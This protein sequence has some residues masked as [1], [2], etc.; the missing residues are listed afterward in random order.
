MLTLEGRVQKVFK[1]PGGSTRDG[2]VVA[3]SARVQIV[4]EVPV[5]GGDSKLA[6][7][8]L[9]VTDRVAAFQ[10]AMGKLVRCQVD[11]WNMEGRSGLFLLKDSEIELLDEKGVKVGIANA[12]AA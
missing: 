7:V 6:I 4:G 8:E 11:L 2:E 1:V 3:P 9:K 5:K 12:K 10:Q